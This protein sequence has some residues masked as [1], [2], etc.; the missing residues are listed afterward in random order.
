MAST[1]RCSR[2]LMACR[3]LDVRALCGERAIAKTSVGV[4]VLVEINL[5]CIKF[6]RVGQLGV[7]VGLSVERTERLRHTVAPGG[8]RPRR[9]RA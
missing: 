8:I 5:T 1:S 7:T 4:R 6:K 9:P 3:T 2:C